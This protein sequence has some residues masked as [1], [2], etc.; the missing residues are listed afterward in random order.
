MVFGMPT[1]IE[2]PEIEDTLKLCRDLSLSFVELNMNLPQYQ[3]HSLEDNE[4]YLNELR[5]KY[6]LYYTIH[7]DE[8]LNIADFNNDVRQAYI[9]TVMKTIDIAKSSVALC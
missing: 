3:T 8:N 6:Q 1:L 4:E 7:L 9:L 2:I 5:E